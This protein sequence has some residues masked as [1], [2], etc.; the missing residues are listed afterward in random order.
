MTAFTVSRCNEESVGSQPSPHDGMDFCFK[1]H[2]SLHHHKMMW[3][4]ALLIT[5]INDD[6]DSDNF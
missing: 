3:Q 5:E 2:P 1:S 4:L 6:G